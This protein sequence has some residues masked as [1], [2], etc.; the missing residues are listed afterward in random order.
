MASKQQSD[1]DPF[2]GLGDFEPRLDIDVVRMVDH[3]N[4]ALTLLARPKSRMKK[5]EMEALMIAVQDQLMAAREGA[6]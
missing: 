5:N 3:I 4:L 6:A 2:G 1:R